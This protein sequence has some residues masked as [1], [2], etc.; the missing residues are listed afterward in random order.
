MTAS[1]PT[2]HRGSSSAGDA[3]Q[4]LSL[5]AAEPSRSTL[6]ARQVEVRFGGVVAL[7]DV[8]LSFHSGVIK[9]VIGPN[10]AGKT[11]LFDALSG[12][13]QPTAGS[14]LFDGVEVSNRSPT[15]RARQGIRR[16]FQRQQTFG[17]LS[18][19]D[20]LLCALEWRG[21]GGGLLGDLV[22]APGRRFRERQRRERVDEVLELSGLDAV[23]STLAGTL[24]IGRARIVE[25]ARAII[26]HPRM[27][28]L[29]EPTSGLEE[30]E[31][32]RVG[33]LI[34][35][36]RGN[37]GCGIALVEHDIGFVMRE[38]DRVAVLDLGSVLAEGTP[39]EIR[40]DDAV[41]AAYLG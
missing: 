19:E 34:Q 12:I 41:M 33:D 24:P 7:H 22:R 37:E 32:E 36:V 15:W 14:V 5:A 18:V 39:E 35:Q 25:I 6:E 27:L 8:S 1:G 9:G 38:C 17:W 21:G 20:N 28:L 11:T 2:D 16:T 13:C 10:G 40:N 26:D 3:A 4:L 31:V 30:S 29:D 23:R